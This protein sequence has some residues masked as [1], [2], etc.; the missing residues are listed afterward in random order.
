MNMRYLL[1]TFFLS[2]PVFAQHP[3]FNAVQIKTTDLGDGIY[4]LEGY[5]GNIGVS[6]GED[7]VF[8]IDDQFAPLTPKI[9]AAISKVTDKLV[10]YV[11]NTH[12]HGDHVGGNENLAKLGAVIVAHDN[13]R[14]RMSA[15][16]PLK[17]PD[18][19]LPVITFS[20]TTTF[21]FNGHEIHASHPVQAHTDG[22]AIIHFRNIDLIHA[23]DIL[24]N[25]MYP[26]IDL[27]SGGSIDGYIAALEQLAGMAKA[28]TRIIPG[29]GPM[30]SRADVEKSIAM[31]KG[32]K[33]K[34]AKLVNK[35]KSLEQVKAADP[36]AEYHAI[37]AWPFITA[38]R[39]TEIMYR[40]LNQ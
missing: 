23:G 26:F 9:L 38:E 16:G 17:S 7:G 12:W 19:A 35:G 3:D 14:V 36:L 13:V 20:E 11:I 29:H 18:G 33:S 1:L 30:A 2:I 37:W 32:A 27:D 31:L 21:H 40:A 8:V 22:D 25:G 15:E 39:M 34:V 10:D 4:M 28:D 6:V 5:G 24:F